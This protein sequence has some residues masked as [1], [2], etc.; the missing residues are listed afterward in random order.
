MAPGRS[1]SYDFRIRR[2]D[3]EVDYVIK[4]DVQSTG[5]LFAPNG[6]I[7]TPV[8]LTLGSDTVAPISLTPGDADGEYEFEVTNTGSYA[9]FFTLKVDWPW[10]TE[11]FIDSNGNSYDNLWADKAGNIKVKVVVEQ[12]K[13]WGEVATMRVRM[14]AAESAY[15][16]IAAYIGQT[17]GQPIDKT[18][19]GRMVIEGNNV[20]FKANDPMFGAVE[21]NN[22]ALS[23]TTIGKTVNLNSVY[24][25]GGDHDANITSVNTQTW[26]DFVE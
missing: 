24:N 11:N 26:L 21:L 9:D 2:N 12:K 5:E 22:K 18:I 23:F 1:E 15:S 3:T 8:L 25:I 17:D 16:A 20:T 19:T 13:D 14:K 10:E 4:V 7:P 6:E